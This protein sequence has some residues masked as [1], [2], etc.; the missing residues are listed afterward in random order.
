MPMYRSVHQQS[1]ETQHALKCRCS[2]CH[3]KVDLFPRNEKGTI[4]LPHPHPSWTQPLGNSKHPSGPS[5]NVG[6]PSMTLKDASSA[7][8]AHRLWKPSLRGP[9]QPSSPTWANNTVHGTPKAMFPSHPS[10]SMPP[11][12]LAMAS[13]SQGVG[14]SS[15]NVDLPPLRSVSRASG[16]LQASQPLPRVNDPEMAHPSWHPQ[17]HTDQRSSNKRKAAEILDGR[18]NVPGPTHPLPPSGVRNDIQTGSEPSPKRQVR[19]STASNR[20]ITDTRDG[21]S[22]ASF[23]SGS[24]PEMGLT[25]KRLARH[26]SLRRSE[27]ASTPAAPSRLGSGA[28]TPL[29]QATFHPSPL[30]APSTGQ[31]SNQEPSLIRWSSRPE[32]FHSE[33]V[34]TTARLGQ[35]RGSADRDAIQSDPTS[36]ARTPTAA[37]D[38]MDTDDTSDSTHH[39]GQG[40][41]HTRIRTNPIRFREPLTSTSRQDRKVVKGGVSIVQ[42][43]WDSDRKRRQGYFAPD[44]G[45]EKSPFR[46]YSKDDCCFDD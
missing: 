10:H 28:S 37:E 9:G 26:G 8:Q 24:N 36:N 19:R 30:P 14:S 3:L 11:T 23:D 46:H 2:D 5:S 22:P 6:G 35:R 21:A 44:N 1:S 45:S 41:L 7:P 39:N 20:A 29:P 40:V 31:V 16:S 25:K 17:Q 4:L 18:E 34:V 27:G 42:V 32:S 15:F 33:G 38:E 13:G 43:K 12:S